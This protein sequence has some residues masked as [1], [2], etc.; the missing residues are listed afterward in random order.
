MS[1]K[2]FDG[3]N[4]V[5][6]NDIT[7]FDGSKR[8]DTDINMRFDGSSWVEIWNRISPKDTITFYN[9]LFYNQYQ[10]E[11]N[12]IYKILCNKC[13]N[14]IL[15]YQSYNYQNG[16]YGSHWRKVTSTNNNGQ[17]F[18]L[19]PYISQMS[20]AISIL[21]GRLNAGAS[22]PSTGNTN[23]KTTVVTRQQIKD[24]GVFGGVNYPWSIYTN[25]GA[26]IEKNGYIK[27]PYCE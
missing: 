3:S 10:S 23:Q 26:D 27:C 21:F 13:N 16:D 12:D 15:S 2:R 25:A 8:V 7:R 6:I 1:T 14:I 11:N 24:T 18:E 4:W 5:E 20:N 9:S 22:S 19:L 17:N